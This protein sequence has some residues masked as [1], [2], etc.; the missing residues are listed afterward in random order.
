MKESFK[1]L[2]RGIHPAKTEM[3]DE[4][5]APDHSATKHRIT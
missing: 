3:V 1:D 2:I 5:V 4:A